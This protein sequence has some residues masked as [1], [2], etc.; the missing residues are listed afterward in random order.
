MVISLLKIHMYTV[1]TYK[2]MVLGHPTRELLRDKP[3]LFSNSARQG[4]MNTSL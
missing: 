2:C 1:Y 4:G 3:H